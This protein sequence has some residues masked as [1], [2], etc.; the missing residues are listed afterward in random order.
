MVTDEDKKNITQEGVEL[1]LHKKDNLDAEETAEVRMS[2][3]KKDTTSEYVNLEGILFNTLNVLK[4]YNRNKSTLDKIGVGWNLIGELAKATKKI[5]DYVIDQ[6]EQAK[7][8]EHRQEMIDII[9][10]SGEIIQNLSNEDTNKEL[11]ENLREERNK[12]VQ[13]KINE[14]QRG[15][16]DETH[17]YY[18]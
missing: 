3:Y 17:F 11:L 13:A 12:L 18:Y 8:D 10:I 16:E 4:N 7:Q 14:L 6:Q 15:M 5:Y 1:N 9:A 2:D